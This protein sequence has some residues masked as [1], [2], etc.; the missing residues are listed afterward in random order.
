MDMGKYKLKLLIREAIQQKDDR[1]LIN[2][3]LSY[4][5]NG[6]DFDVD[7]GTLLFAKAILCDKRS[8]K[9]RDYAKINPEA[10]ELCKLAIE[11]VDEIR[12]MDPE[13]YKTMCSDGEGRKYRKFWDDGTKIFNIGE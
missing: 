10:L 3:T 2:A 13:L 1:D 6:N 11:K 12:S 4:L 9:N 8:G 5:V 7:Q